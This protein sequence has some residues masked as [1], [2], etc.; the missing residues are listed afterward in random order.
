MHKWG[1]VDSQ[2]CNRSQI[3]T[4]RQ[5]VEEC[6]KTKFRGGTSG[7]HKGDKEALDKSSYLNI[8]NYSSYE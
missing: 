6:P 4:I 7:L 2:L 5:I 1:M 3:Q 8:N